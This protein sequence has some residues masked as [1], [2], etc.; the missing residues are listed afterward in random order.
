VCALAGM[1]PYYTQCFLH[2]PFV[3]AYSKQRTCLSSLKNVNV[4]VFDTSLITLDLS[5]PSTSENNEKIK[6]AIDLMQSKANNDPN[7]GDALYK[8][9]LLLLQLHH[10]NSENAFVSEALKF[11]KAAVATNPNIDGAWYNIG[12]ILEEQGDKLMS[13]SDFPSDSISINPNTYNNEPD[14]DSEIENDTN[15]DSAVTASNTLYEEAIQAYKS[16]I[17]SS[18]N[19]SIKSACYNN[20]VRIYTTL[21]LVDSAAL[22]C[23]EAVQAN[24][25]DAIGWCNMGVILVR[26]EV[27]DYAEKCFLNALE[28]SDNTNT[29]ALNNLAFLNKRNGRTDMAEMYLRAAVSIDPSDISSTYALGMLLV[30]MREVSQA[31][32]LFQKCLDANPHDEQAA[33]QL[34]LITMSEGSDETE[35]VLPAQY[36]KQLFDFYAVAGYEDHMTQGL[37]YRGPEILWN[38]FS[39]EVRDREQRDWYALDLGCGTGLVGKTFRALL[40][41]LRVLYGC[42]LSSGMVTI[43]RETRVPTPSVSPLDDTVQKTKKLTNSSVSS[44]SST[45]TRTLPVYDSVAE[46]D[47]SAYLSTLISETRTAQAASP[48]SPRHRLSYP[49]NLLLAGDVLGYL[50][51]LSQLFS[52]ARELLSKDGVFVFTVEKMTTETHQH[53]HQTGEDD[54]NQLGSSPSY[55]LAE[56]GRFVHSKSYVERLAEKSGFKVV[57]CESSILRT[58][59]GSPVEGIVYVFFAT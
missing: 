41:T 33:F 49:W 15:R 51:D 18:T 48:A 13:R 43:A 9:G 2:Y 35:A 59:N 5:N 12:S 17:L 53:Q 52:R 20:I 32:T 55:V 46:Q 24:P 1:S 28:C 44:V 37:G 10:N 21:N 16:A 26:D 29:I 40:P 57:S 38:A 34:Q 31:K 36:V 27:Y 3:K 19:P 4:P 56:G 6:L 7:D 23:N 11:F 22:T 25:D 42:D 8:I 39:T 58:Q 50:G 14:H 45:A 30:E 54:G 47:C